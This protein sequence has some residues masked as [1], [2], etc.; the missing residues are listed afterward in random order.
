MPSTQ[1]M[2]YTTPEWQEIQNAI[3]VVAP[4]YGE[5]QLLSLKCVDGKWRWECKAGVLYDY[6]AV[7]IAESAIERWL[8]DRQ[9]L[10]QL[11]ASVFD[12]E[13]I[14]LSVSL[15]D[16]TTKVFYEP[17]DRKLLLMSRGANRV[18]LGLDDSDG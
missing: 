14:K 18:E 1:E 12:C 13:K 2:P 11:S 10:R 15:S 9:A 16:K 4:T 3:T 7:P 6:I 8:W 5:G 17:I